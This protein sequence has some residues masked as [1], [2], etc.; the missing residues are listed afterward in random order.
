[1]NNSFHSN[2]KPSI[3]WILKFERNVQMCDDD[4]VV[5][6]ALLRWACGEGMEPAV[7]DFPNK[8]KEPQLKRRY[9]DILKFSRSVAISVLLVA[10]PAVYQHNIKSNSAVPLQVMPFYTPHKPMLTNL[11]YPFHLK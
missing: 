3:F 6:V 9:N 1:M 7:S 10:G 8:S 11:T 2:K 4:V 5:D